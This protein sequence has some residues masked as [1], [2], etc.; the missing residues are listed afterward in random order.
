MPDSRYKNRE[1]DERFNELDRRLFHEK[2]GFLPR[3]LAQT[4]KTNGRVTRLERIM[5]I[6][7]TAVVSLLATNGSQVFGFIHSIL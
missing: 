3:M 7:G 4:T 2:E 6:I 5:L 1:I